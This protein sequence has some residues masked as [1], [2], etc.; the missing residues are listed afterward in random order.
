M[1]ILTSRLLT[2]RFPSAVQTLGMDELALP[3][4]PPL[5]LP[6]PC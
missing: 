3:L 5:A 4:R 6:V 2:I 1:S